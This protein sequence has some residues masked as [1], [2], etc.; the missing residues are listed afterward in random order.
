MDLPVGHNLQDHV[1]SDGI[2]FFTPHAG[3][4]I[5]AVKGE[6]FWQS[7]SYFLFGAGTVSHGYH[8]LAANYHA[9]PPFYS[10][11]SVV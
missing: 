4:A 6:N 7:W 10:D 2:E 1:M 8:H 11:Y 9:A 3:V 5:T